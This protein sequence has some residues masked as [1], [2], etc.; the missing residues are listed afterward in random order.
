[1]PA[2]ACAGPSRAA[3]PAFAAG[4]NHLIEF[5]VLKIPCRLKYKEPLLQKLGQL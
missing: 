1:M 2:G 5:I 4:D 3:E